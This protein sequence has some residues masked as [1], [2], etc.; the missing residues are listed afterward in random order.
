MFLFFVKCIVQVRNREEYD[1]HPAH[2]VRQICQIYVNLHESDSFCLAVSQDGRSYSHQLFQFAE[3]ILGEFKEAVFRRCYIL[4]VYVLVKIGGGPIGEMREVAE[5]VDRLDKR[6]RADQEALSDPPDE[7]LDPIMSTLMM[8]PV[9]L[10]SSKVTV[11]RTTIA[12]H[13]LSDQTD[14][15]N[16]SPLTMDQVQGDVEMR[17]KIEQWIREKREAYSQQRQVV[18]EEEKTAED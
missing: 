7:F 3:Q 5:K 17:G 15:F 4:W 12:R 1:F 9:I 14:P 18:E 13:L 8:D 10:P 16:R 6:Q 11:D 2:T